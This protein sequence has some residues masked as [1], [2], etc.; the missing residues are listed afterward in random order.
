MKLI[1]LPLLSLAILAA[2][3]RSDV[4]DAAMRGDQAA[5]RKLLEQHT[6]VNAPQNDGGLLDFGQRS[7][8]SR[9]ALESSA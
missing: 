7:F 3:G 6:D 9:R 1:V 8:V 2:A 5:V 4:A